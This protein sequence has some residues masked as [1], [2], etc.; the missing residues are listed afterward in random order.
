MIK[1]RR[2]EDE[3]GSD[4]GTRLTAELEL[5]SVGQ[6]ATTLRLDSEEAV[7]SVQNASDLRTYVCGNK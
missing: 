5:S 7:F 4:E 1:E 6:N 3:R 2:M